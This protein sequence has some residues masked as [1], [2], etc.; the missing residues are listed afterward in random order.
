MRGLGYPNN[1][2]AVYDSVLT[3][4]YFLVELAYFSE[5]RD[6]AMKSKKQLTIACPSLEYA[7]VLIGQLN[8]VL[9]GSITIA[10]LSF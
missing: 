8:T 4:N 9:N 1:F 3:K 6:D 2:D 10:E 5:G 7:N